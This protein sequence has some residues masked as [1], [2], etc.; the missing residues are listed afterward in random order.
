MKLS[1]AIVPNFLIHKLSITARQFSVIGSET[2]TKNKQLPPFA[3]EL[4]SMKRD[5][6]QTT[7][8]ILVEFT[9]AYYII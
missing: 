3:S 4:I 5:N 9:V 1:L 7:F 6:S 2:M 8:I